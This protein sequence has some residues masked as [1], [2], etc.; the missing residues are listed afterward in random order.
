MKRLPI[1]VHVTIFVIAAALIFFK[2]CSASSYSSRSGKP[3]SSSSSQGKDVRFTDADDTHPA[4]TN[5]TPS[6]HSPRI[7]EEFEEMNYET[8]ERDKEIKADFLK[9]YSSNSDELRTR[10]LSSSN[11]AMHDK[12]LM[13][14]VKYLDTPYKY[15]GS[16]TKGIDCS[17]F[18]KNVYSGSNLGEIPRSAREQY[19]AGTEVSLDNLQ[20][21]DL[22]FFNTRRKVRPG[23]VGIYIGDG[24][25]VHSSR[26]LGVAVSAMSEPYYSKRYM[27]ARRFPQN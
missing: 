27:G 6:P 22:V 13:E 1:S 25:F 4:K 18:T 12:M 3:S 7:E 16:T 10:N 5:Q 24:Y 8:I 11:S 9:R 20:F 19:K 23:H 14:I 2:G 17:A 26:S 15:G 21:G